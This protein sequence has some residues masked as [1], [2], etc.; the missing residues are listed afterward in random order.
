[1]FD[2]VLKRAVFPGEDGGLASERATFVDTTMPPL[3]RT[4]QE[5]LAHK[6]SHPLGPCSRPVLRQGP[7]VVPGVGEAPSE[8]S[9]A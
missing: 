6:E 4:L 7:A 5:Y 9:T 8:R 1:M 3:P 2:T